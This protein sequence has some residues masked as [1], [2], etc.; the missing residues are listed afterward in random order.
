MYR[1][2]ELKFRRYMVHLYLINKYQDNFP[3]YFKQLM[4]KIFLFKYRKRHYYILFKMIICYKFCFHWVLASLHLANN[5][6]F[7]SLNTS[8]KFGERQYQIYRATWW[9]SLYSP[10]KIIRTVPGKYKTFTK[11][12]LFL[13]N[14]GN[15]WNLQQSR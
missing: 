10:C 12:Y 7:M 4:P 3:K 8:I 14:P 1:M 11:Y 13:G 5:L 6:T 2:D 15:G 9:N